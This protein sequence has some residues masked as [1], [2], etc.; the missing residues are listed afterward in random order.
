MKNEISELIKPT[1]LSMGYELWGLNV[2][3][4]N[5][6]LKFTLYIDSVNG[7]N[8]DDCEKVSNQV[9]HLLDTEEVCGSEYVLEV[10]SPGFDR[11][12]ITKEH[13]DRY[14]KEKVKVKL[15]WLVNNRKNIKGVIKEV[16]DDCVI[17]DDENESYEIKYDS[18]DSARLKI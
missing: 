10:S 3:Q 12:L 18:I 7:I 16:T 11:I 8:I 17:I 14:I 9:T 13:F 4:Q 5:N 2:G 6:S 1:I 15:K